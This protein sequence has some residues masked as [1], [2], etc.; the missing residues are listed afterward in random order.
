MFWYFSAQR[1]LT[2][3]I[4]RRV[5][6]YIKFICKISIKQG[7][8]RPSWKDIFLGMFMILSYNCNFGKSYQGLIMCQKC[9][10]CYCHALRLIIVLLILSCVQR[11]YL[12]LTVIVSLFVCYLKCILV[13]AYWT[14]S[15]KKNI[16]QRPPIDVITV[17]YEIKI[18][19]RIINYY[20]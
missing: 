13:E 15:Y 6:K 16:I 3:L 10:S 14:W 5:C 20:D 7:L 9:Q 17:K 19:S 18:W 11:C 12:S 4:L 2:P 1:N 8:F